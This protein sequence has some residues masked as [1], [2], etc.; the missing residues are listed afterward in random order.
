MNVELE[1]FS[2]T[3]KN[4]ST[5]ELHSERDAL[6]AELAGMTKAERDSVRGLILRAR[7]LARAREL[8]QRC[9]VEELL[10]A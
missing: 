3:L 2:F 10:A 8:Q 6:R 5:N 1:G 9:S 4:R 7:I